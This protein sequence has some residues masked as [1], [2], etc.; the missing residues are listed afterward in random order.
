[1]NRFSCNDNYLKDFKI[2]TEDILEKTG[3]ASQS[4]EREIMCMADTGNL[5]AI[6]LYADMIFY[7]KLF[8]KNHY[9]EAFL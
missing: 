1:M 7:R 2:Y 4:A 6:K 3:I 8:K 5:V 9:R